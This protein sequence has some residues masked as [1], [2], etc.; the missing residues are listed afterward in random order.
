MGS[1]PRAHEVSVH[2]DITGKAVDYL[3][4]VR[5]ELKA[6]SAELKQNLG[7]GVT[8]EDNY[9]FG[10]LGRFFFHFRPPLDDEAKT[11]PVPAHAEASCDSL[12]WGETNTSCRATLTVGEARLSVDVQNNVPYAEVLRRLREPPGSEGHRIG[13]IG[14]GHYLHLLQDLTSPAHARN[15]AHPHFQR[16]HIGDWPAAR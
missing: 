7:R 3:V 10:P 16:R 15:D 12:L 13:L 14:L 8:E 4:D 5:P 9:L 2:V 11:L 6:C 1:A